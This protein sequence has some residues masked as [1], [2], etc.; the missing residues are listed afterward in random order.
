MRNRHH[1]EGCINVG[2][3]S[4]KHCSIGRSTVVWLAML[5]AGCMNMSPQS[6]MTG[7]RTIDSPGP[8]GAADDYQARRA[9]PQ[10]QSRKDPVRPKANG[11]L[12]LPKTDEAVEA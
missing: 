6:R 4:A 10:L 5:L 8:L 2:W 7:W 1:Q 3:H 9:A 11:A 12:P